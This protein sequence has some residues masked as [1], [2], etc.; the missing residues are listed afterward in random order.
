MNIIQ[1]VADI[2]M[3]LK[4]SY[5]VWNFF[6]VHVLLFPKRMKSVTWINIALVIVTFLDI[7]SWILKLD[8]KGTI[9][10]PFMEHVNHQM[11]LLMTTI[12]GWV[13][14]YDWCANVFRFESCSWLK[15][16]RQI[17]SQTSASVYSGVNGL[18]SGNVGNYVGMTYSYMVPWDLRKAHAGADLLKKA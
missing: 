1:T 18:L 5:H 4:G 17:L 15:G 7:L 2:H 10:I 14:K 9:I 8:K 12:Y 3:V 6:D 16:V 11:I 13:D